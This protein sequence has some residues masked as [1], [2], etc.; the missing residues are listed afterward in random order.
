MQSDSTLPPPDGGFRLG[1][2]YP[3]T[4]G[5]HLLSP[6]AAER[7]P[8]VLAAASH[9]SVIQA[10][11]RAGLDYVFAADAWGGRGP[12]SKQLG[13]SDPMLFAPVLA[14]ILI[15]ASEHIKII[16][17]MHQAMLH[18]LQIARM[19]ANLDA[20]SGG[21]W[22]MNAVSGAGYAPEL[23]KSL[24]PVSDHDALYDA[25][26]ES[27]EIILQAWHNGGEVDFE[28]AHYQVKG[29]LV[30][31]MP[32]QRPHPLIVSAGA[33]PAGCEFAGKYA[34]AL[35]MPGRARAEMIDDRREKVRL[36]AE[37]AGREL[38]DARV[39]LHA[40][41]LIGET[42][43]EAETLSAELRASVD[44][45]AVHEYLAGVTAQIT[46]FEEL[47]SSYGEDQLRDVGLTAGTRR[48]HGDPKHVADGI[49]AL[50]EETSRDGISLSFPLWQ[51]DQ[52]RRFA[53][54]VVPLLQADGVWSPADT[55]GWSW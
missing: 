33:S 51:P 21:R 13:L 23:M 24:A 20:L 15:G 6:L 47:F 54:S 46:T 42:Q 18:P 49:R 45:R 5:L 2:M 29:R 10:A 9:I 40:S 14:G 27:M 28:G 31:P 36:A 38:A 55:R 43:Q 16:T 8:D 37:R 52:I 35:F 30:G 3:T 4:P 41:I 26:A 53:T 39:M 19:G 32:V 1:L 11:E 7:N 22:G 34:S 48:I 50:K 12:A 25:A 44:L 17:T